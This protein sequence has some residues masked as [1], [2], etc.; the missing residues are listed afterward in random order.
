MST[1]ID[2]I[3]KYYNSIETFEKILIP[4]FFVTVFL[5]FTPLLSKEIQAFF[6]KKILTT[7]FAISTVLYFVISQYLRFVAIPQA[8]RM[9]RKQLLSNAYNTPLIH[10]RT[11]L[12]YNNDYT[13]STQR[14]GANILENALFSK[15]I[16][17]KMLKN[18]RLIS[19]LFILVWMGMVIYK[20]SDFDFVMSITQLVFSGSIVINWINLEILNHRFSQVY[21]QMYN[22]FLYD[23]GD[24][25]INGT[26][27]I[28]DAFTEYESAKASAGVKLNS[29][30]FFE[31]NPVV[32]QEWEEIKQTLHMQQDITAL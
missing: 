24:Q 7:L 28:L 11:H 32:T 2:S 29:K 19:I 25:S 5:S 4:I 17:K 22:H 16:T 15:T 3:E 9:R 21:T 20:N 23:I 30:I 14:L 13:P 12:Y 10:E 1:R 6:D 8:E 31:L 27:A 26:A 18:T